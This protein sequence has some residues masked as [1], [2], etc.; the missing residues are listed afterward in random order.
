MARHARR[1]GQDAY[2]LIR[3]QALFYPRAERYAPSMHRLDQVLTNSLLFASCSDVRIEWTWDEGVGAVTDANGTVLNAPGPDEVYGTGDDFRLTG[4]N[5]QTSEPPGPR[6]F[7][8]PDDAYSRLDQRNGVFPY[9]FL[10]PAGKATTI[11]QTNIEEWDIDEDI[12]TY[13]AIFGYNQNSP[14]D[15]AGNPQSN[16]AFTPWPT[17]IRVTLTLHDPAVVFETGRQVQFILEIP[18]RHVDF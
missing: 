11:D 12:K 1:I 16:L 5:Y 3:D 7:G 8:L 15:G 2:S 10:D 13:T 4:V 6:W 9:S 17:A 18:K 14:L